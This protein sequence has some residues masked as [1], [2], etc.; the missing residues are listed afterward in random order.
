[1]TTTSRTKS[2]L[3]LLAAILGAFYVLGIA[4]LISAGTPIIKTLLVMTL[5]ILL[6][7]VSLAGV[8]LCTWLY[9]VVHELG[10]LLAG[11]AVGL[12]L[13]SI[14]IG[15]FEYAVTPSGGRWKKI[16][17][18]DTLK[19]FCR[20]TP[21]DGAFSV[22][23]LKIFLLGGP[24]ANWS[25]FVFFVIAALIAGA[26]PL[27][28]WS[29]ISFL[30]GALWW[31]ALCATIIAFDPLFQRSPSSDLRQLSLLF[32][33]KKSTII[34]N[35]LLLDAELRSET[36][37][38]DWDLAVVDA[39]VKGAETQRERLLANTY[40]YNAY[41]DRGDDDGTMRHLHA[42]VI[43]CATPCG[44]ENI[45]KLML[46]EAAFA[47]ARTENQVQA[48]KEVLGGV[49]ILSQAEPI[50]FGSRHRAEAAI[51][52]AEGDPIRAMAAAEEACQCLRVN[53]PRPETQRPGRN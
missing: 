22:R 19:G 3:W 46:L 1:M 50:P 20:M 5:T 14:Q 8:V 2:S 43:D 12:R 17:S 29:R 45:R 53:L 18:W 42:A 33:K 13:T 9:F 40:A 41:L 27:M 15:P 49:G 37:G 25:I 38:R 6:L 11:R 36:R 44:D 21:K 23:Q 51:A 48:A 26:R 47:F 52:L 28:D 10:H 32:D 7:V 39:V 24:A 4:V 16:A 35:R 34:A 30:Q 31:G